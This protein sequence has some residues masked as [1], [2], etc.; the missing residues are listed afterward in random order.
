MTI[1]ACAFVALREMF[2]AKA[3]NHSNEF[4]SRELTRD[5]GL[6][7]HEKEDKHAEILYPEENKKTEEAVSIGDEVEKP[8]SSRASLMGL[9]DAADEFFDVPE[10][11]DYAFI[12]N[13]WPSDLSVEENSPV[14]TSH[15]A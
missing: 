14:L 7:L 1:S 15:H 3:G 11:A 6:S 12:E 4:S 13:E 10:P 5:I 8:L 2:R 9:N